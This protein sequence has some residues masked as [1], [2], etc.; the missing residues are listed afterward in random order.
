M[1]W[2]ERGARSDRTVFDEA[3]QWPSIAACLCWCYIYGS[4]T[5]ILCTW[6]TANA[7]YGYAGVE[8]LWPWIMGWSIAGLPVA[9][10]ARTAKIHG[11]LAC[12][13]LCLVVAFFASMPRLR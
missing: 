6:V 9:V 1:G 13:G 2:R 5:L 8:A 4:V 10:I 3:A 11:T 7:E 12:A